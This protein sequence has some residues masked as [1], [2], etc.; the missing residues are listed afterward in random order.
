M[1]LPKLHFPEYKFKLRSGTSGGQSLKI[2]DIVRGK[3]VQLTPEEW[4]RQH[5]LHFLIYDRRFPRSLTA[6]E[7]RVVVNR[8][9]RRYDVLVHGP[10]LKPLILVEC[11]APDVQITQDVFDQAARYNLSI[12]ARF[13]ILSNGMETFC[14]TLNHEA[15]TYSFQEEVPFY[16]NL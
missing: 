4:V 8:L 10:D 3:Y 14:C 6:V 15:Q 2:F 11:K 9:E 1:E 16:E 5:I 7:K 12:D 13:F